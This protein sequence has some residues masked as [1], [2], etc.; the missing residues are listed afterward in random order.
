MTAPASRMESVLILNSPATDEAVSACPLTHWRGC[1][2][3]QKSRRSRF[4]RFQF[5]HLYIHLSLMLG[6]HELLAGVSV[7]SGCHTSKQLLN[8]MPEQSVTLQNSGH[9]DMFEIWAAPKCAGLKS[10]AASMCDM[11]YVFVGNAKSIKLILIKRK[12]KLQCKPQQT[13]TNAGNCPIWQQV[14]VWLFKY[15]HMFS[16][17]GK[18]LHL[19]LGQFSKQL[20]HSW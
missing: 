12:K 2:Q 20:I 11:Y 15:V 10:H 19:M 18:C 6:Q 7:S 5:L 4:K 16:C 9:F 13:I 17:M 1:Q 14:N 8:Q 3:L